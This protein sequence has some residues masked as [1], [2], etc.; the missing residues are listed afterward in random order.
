MINRSMD[1]NPI[2]TLFL[3]LFGGGALATLITVLYKGRQD[4]NAQAFSHLNAIVLN[5]RERITVLEREVNEHQDARAIDKEK[6]GRLETGLVECQAKHERDEKQIQ[7]L[8]TDLHALRN[9]LA[10]CPQCHGQLPHLSSPE[11]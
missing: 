11:K 4:F 10:A 8:R 2:V 5:C 1:I 9:R 3:G 6:I 7:Q